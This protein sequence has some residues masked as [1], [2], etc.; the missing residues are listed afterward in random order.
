MNREYAL[1]RMTDLAENTMACVPVALCLDVSGSMAGKP[2]ATPV[3]P[4]VYSY[5]QQTILTIK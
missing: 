4:R 2:V 5:S 3:I 1:I